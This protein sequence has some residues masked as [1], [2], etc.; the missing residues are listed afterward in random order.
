MTMKNETLII[1][2]LKTL[3]KDVREIRATVPKIARI[4]EH[5]K[6]LNGTVQGHKDDIDGLDARCDEQDTK[7]NKI[8]TISSFIMAIGGAVFA[9][10]AW[11]LGKFK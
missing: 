4:E 3:S 8:Y 11:V 7:I 6:N 1:E 9:F 2:N 5:L 10:I